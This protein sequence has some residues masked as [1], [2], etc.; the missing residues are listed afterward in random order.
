MIKKRLL[1]NFFIYSGRDLDSEDIK[2][3]YN[4][5]FYGIRHQYRATNQEANYKRHID[6][7]G[8]ITY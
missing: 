3:Y 2:R 4:R 7:A 8:K 1:I 6:R 5:D